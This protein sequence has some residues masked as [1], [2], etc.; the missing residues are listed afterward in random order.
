MTQNEEVAHEELF[1]FLAVSYWSVK[2]A[3]SRTLYNMPPPGN[4]NRE[5]LKMG[6]FKQQA[7]KQCI[8]IG[9]FF[10]CNVTLTW[11]LYDHIVFGMQC[12]WGE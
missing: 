1:L 5:T 9:L 4:D 7:R 12:V 10:F 3:E 11:V 8:F 6:H 2:A